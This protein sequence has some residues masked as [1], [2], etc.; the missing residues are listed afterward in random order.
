MKK[1]INYLLLAFASVMAF[2]CVGEEIVPN[3]KT[4]RED[5]IMLHIR[6]NELETKTEER[7]GEQARNENLIVNNRVDIFF[8]KEDTPGAIIRKSAVNVLVENEYVRIPVT[9]PEVQNIFN[10]IAQNESTCNVVIVANY[11]GGNA[12][13]YSGCSTRE[14][15]MNLALDTAR[16]SNLTQDS[17]VMV[18]SA[19]LTL[20]NPKGSTPAKGDVRL[21]RVAAKVS[22][23]MTVASSTS[24]SGTTWTPNTGS[25]SIYLVYAMR[26]AVLGGTP[27]P[28]PTGINKVDYRVVDCDKDNDAAYDDE[29]LY[30]YQG[31][32][33]VDSGETAERERDGEMEE[34]T[35]Y[36]AG[37]KNG[38]GTVLDSDSP[39]YTYPS[40]WDY[41]VATEPYLKL[42]IPWTTELSGA[43]R[44]KYYYYKIP[45]AINT[46]ESNNWY[47]IYID[48]KI[49]GGEEPVPP[50]ATISYCISDWEGEVDMSTATVVTEITVI[51]AQV[52]AARYLS[53]P[54]TEYILYNTDDLVIPITSSHPVEVVGFSV[55]ET[56]AYKDD[57]MVDANYVGTNPKVYNPFFKDDEHLVED[58]IVI[59][60]PDYSATEVSA[61]TQ[62]ITFGANPSGTYGW[63]VKA[64]ATGKE[65][66]IVH[67]TLNRDL[68]SENYDV[69]PYTIRMRIR[70]ADEFGESYYTDVMVEQ[71]PPI[72]IHPEA[73]AGG[74]SNYGYAFVNGA[75]N[76]SPSSNSASGSYTASSV[77]NWT[78]YLGSSPG[79]LSNSSNTNTNMY[80][81][82]TSVLPT[83]GTISQYMLGDPRQL[84]PYNLNGSK[85]SFTTTNTNAATWST[86][87]N[88]WGGT[89]R[90][91]TYYYPVGTDTSYNKVIA[92]RIRIAS[93]FGAT[94]YL[95]YYDAFRRCASYQESG[96]PAG[97]WRVPTKAEIEYIAQ[98]NADGKIPLLLGNTSGK[99]AYWC[100][101]G[102]VVVEL[103]KT[104]SY[105]Q[106]FTQNNVDSGRT[107]VRCVYDDW[108]WSESDRAKLPDNK[109]NTFTWGDQDSSTV[110]IAE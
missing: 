61:D 8:F 104:P 103:G 108:Y 69:A 88:D 82:E 23:N 81:I 64:D 68:S 72:Q 20:I 43:T 59:S 16:W 62:E 56:N 74:K 36:V 42:I 100:N 35:V 52:V 71:R 76:G 33:L 91:L 3:N 15:L 14:D 70:H 19:T 12:S 105:T 2:S 31:R 92:P 87:A 67:H 93:S 78:Y 77:Q 97:R 39:F 37:I 66:V 49:L 102:Y 11:S 53:V 95:T 26:H 30:E 44:T 107:Y 32:N 55:D 4:V 24:E 109:I 46:L 21:K 17:F 90:A 98:L 27:T 106:A 41:G 7:P 5:G 89:N 63:S 10:G 18:G 57:H 6:T 96:Y 110:N 86:S 73:N 80:I 1:I 75:Q 94:Q 47:R 25:M 13:V 34:C 99:T 48:V 9:F 54:T 28:V 65:Q 85:T 51:P 38:A 29:L 58:K 101:S 83:T 40:T 45:F 22:F 79:N 60:K 84:T 50:V